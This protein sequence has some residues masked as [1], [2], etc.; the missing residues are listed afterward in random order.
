MAAFSFFFFTFQMFSPFHVSPS[1]IPYLILFSPASMK[2]L[3]HP[4]NPSSLPS[5]AFPYTGASKHLQT[6]GTLL[7][8]MYKAI[9]CHICGWSHR[10]LHVYSL[11]G[12]PAWGELWGES[13][14]LKVLL[15]LWGC[16][17]PQLFQ[18]L[19]QLPHQGPSRSVQWLAVSICLCI[20]Q[21]LAEPLRRQP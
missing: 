21:A 13:D 5:L 8:L 17:T 20:C 2:V 7:P 11:V 16:K 3:P 1:E 15:L 12:G 6:Q 10:P 4:P 19:L 9:H 18:S 14:L